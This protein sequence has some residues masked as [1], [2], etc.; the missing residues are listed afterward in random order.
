MTTPADACVRTGG[1]PY[2]EPTFASLY[3]EG[4]NVSERD[5]WVRA[6][7]R[8]C[9]GGLLHS[10]VNRANSAHVAAVTRLFTCIRVRAGPY[11]AWRPVG[12]HSVTVVTF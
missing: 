6:S 1:L 2:T 5:G 10:G 4:C 8:Q 3:R 11:C 7:K 12:A 9:G